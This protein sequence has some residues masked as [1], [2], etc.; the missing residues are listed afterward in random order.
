MARPLRL[1]FSGAL[2][3][4]TLRGNE[5][6]SIFLGEV[7]K[8][9]AALL[10]VVAG[11]CKR[12]SWI[13]HAYCFMSDHHPLLVEMPDAAPSKVMRQLNG[14]YTQHV[15]PTH[16]R[17]RHL[18]QGRFKAILVERESYLLEL[19]SYAVLN[20]V[21]AGMVRT[22]GEWPW[23]GYLATAGETPAPEFVATDRLLRA[24]AETRDDAVVRYRRFVA[25]GIGAAGRRMDFKGQIY[26]GSEPFVALVQ[27]LI[28][29]NRQLQ[30]IPKC[31]L[32]AQPQPL[33][34]YVSCYPDRERP[35]AEA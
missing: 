25:E 30:E 21:R 9:R 16:G 15:N 7:D 26:L 2:C 1:E 22:P 10:D 33:D 34:E 20:L 29:P 32:R 18:F 4:V 27:A 8:V 12:F 11:T 5:R 28:D 31:Q 17:V 24:F 6:C 19:A 23:S 3:H 14:I 35:L 13:C